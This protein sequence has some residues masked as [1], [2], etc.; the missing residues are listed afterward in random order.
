MSSKQLLSINATLTCESDF[1]N[2]KFFSNTFCPLVAVIKMEEKYI[3][4]FYIKGSYEIVSQTKEFTKKEGLN[5]SS[6][7]NHLLGERS[8][9]FSLL[10]IIWGLSDLFSLC[11]SFLS[12]SIFLDD[13][14]GLS[15][16]SHQCC[17]FGYPSLISEFVFS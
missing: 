8:N 9:Y 10:T 5:Y 16:K 3:A 6:T 14:N 13:F 12:F 2:F 4:I 1:Y 11:Y 15:K 17:I 7:V